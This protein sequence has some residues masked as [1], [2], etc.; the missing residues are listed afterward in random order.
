LKL[1]GPLA[2]YVDFTR[3]AGGLFRHYEL[4]KNYYIDYSKAQLGGKFVGIY[5][6]EGINLLFVMPDGKIKVQ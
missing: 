1:I 6:D 2:K 4:Q 5:D 3:Y